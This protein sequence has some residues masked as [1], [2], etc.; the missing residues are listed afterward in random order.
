GGLYITSAVEG[1]SI[2]LRFAGTDVDLL[3]PPGVRH[4]TI[5]VEVDGKPA[6]VTGPLKRGSD[7]QTML[8]LSALPPET[9]HVTVV[10]G[11]DSDRPQAEH[12]LRLTLGPDSAVALSGITVRYER[13]VQSFAGYGLLGVA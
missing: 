7:G 12:H 9:R 3:L 11:L 10:A 1:A 6:P 13:S 4:G 2:E 5:M 8:D